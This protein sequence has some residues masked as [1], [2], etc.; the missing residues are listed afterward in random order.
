MY[1]SH[2]LPPKKKKTTNFHLFFCKRGFIKKRKTGLKTFVK[3]NA[4]E[5]QETSPLKLAHTLLAAIHLIVKYFAK[6]QPDD[7]DSNLTKKKIFSF[8]VF[9]VIFKKLA[10]FFLP[11]P[12]FSKTFSK[13]I[14]RK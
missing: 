9:S 7:H 3:I 6:L 5:I 8:T 11:S 1:Q 2:P 13:E 10:L 4:E 12:S 14:M